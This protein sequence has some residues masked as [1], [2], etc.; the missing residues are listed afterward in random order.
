MIQHFFL[1]RINGFS[2]I[3]FT[4]NCDCDWKLFKLL[5]SAIVNHQS[6]IFFH[7]DYTNFHRFFWLKTATATENFL[8]FWNQQSLIINRQSFFTQITQIFTDFFYWKLRLRLKTFFTRITFTENCDCD[9]K[10]FNL[11]KSTIV[12][13]QSKIIMRFLVPRNDKMLLVKRELNFWNQQSLIN[14][15]QS[16]FFTQITQIFTDFFSL[17]SEIFSVL[18][19]WTCFRFSL[20]L[21]LY[22]MLK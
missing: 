12:N 6:T 8:N 19:S 11:L 1:P 9:W 18:S 2:R 10:L 20:V 15:R 13:L 21:Q 3:I 14:N 4:K 5:K 7:T 17:K 16:F 22:K